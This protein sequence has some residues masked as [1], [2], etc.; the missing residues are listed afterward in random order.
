MLLGSKGV[1]KDNVGNWNSRNNYENRRWGATP[2]GGI[3]ASVVTGGGR[4]DA[5]YVAVN[6]AAQQRRIIEWGISAL[7]A[8]MVLL[9]HFSLSKR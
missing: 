9:E 7:C 8:F 5:T 2:T 6:D 1:N 4:R 3:I